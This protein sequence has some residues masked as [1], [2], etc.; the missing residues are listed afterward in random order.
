MSLWA[1]A[2]GG[3]LVSSAAAQRRGP[4][5][6]YDQRMTPDDESAGRVGPDRRYRNLPESVPLDETIASV[7][8]RPVLDGDSVRNVDQDN[9]IR[10]G[11]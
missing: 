10:A 5:W 11:G 7:D 2:A 1:A 8:S 9:A 6:E 3:N 4:A